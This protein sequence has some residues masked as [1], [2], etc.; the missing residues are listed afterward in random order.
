MTNMLEEIIDSLRIF[1]IY[2]FVVS[3]VPADGLALLASRTS[4]GT[5]MNNRYGIDTW[6]HD[7]MTT[8]SQ[9]TFSSACFLMKMFE[10]WLKFHHSLFLRV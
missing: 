10:F 5:A 9:M 1:D 7:K 3:S 6:G 4:N 8:I 2:S